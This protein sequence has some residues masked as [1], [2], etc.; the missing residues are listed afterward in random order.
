MKDNVLAGVDTSN[1]P[2][3]RGPGS[4]DIHVAQHY[5]RNP[6]DE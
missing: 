4:F 2:S 5:V 6:C 1:A 3:L